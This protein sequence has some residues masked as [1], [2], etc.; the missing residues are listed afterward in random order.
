MFAFYFSMLNRSGEISSYCLV[1]DLGEKVFSLSSLSMID[2]GF[3]YLAFI[4]LSWF[5]SGPTLVTISII[6]R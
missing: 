2:P 3:L 4:M 5:Y 1:L 6:K